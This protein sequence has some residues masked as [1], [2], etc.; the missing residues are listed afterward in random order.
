MRIPIFNSFVEEL[1]KYY[2][3][4]GI[5][6][7]EQKD[8]MN[9]NDTFTGIVFCSVQ[10]LKADYEKKKDVLQLFDCNIFD[11]DKYENFLKKNVNL[12][13]G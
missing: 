5:E 6:H 9:I 1:D 4:K 10:Y 11:D 8:Y 7:K 12:L 2:E 3:F 13:L